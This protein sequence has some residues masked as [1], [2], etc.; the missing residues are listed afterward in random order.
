MSKIG[1]SDWK[2]CRMKRLTPPQWHVSTKKIGQRA[3]VTRKW[4]DCRTSTVTA[5]TNIMP[6]VTHCK[7]EKTLKL[8]KK[9]SP[10]KC[11]LIQKKFKWKCLLLTNLQRLK[12]QEYS[13]SPLTPQHHTLRQSS[14]QTAHIWPHL[15][16]V[17]FIRSD[18]VKLTMLRAYSNHILHFYHLNYLVEAWHTKIQKD[19]MPYF[20]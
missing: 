11:R 14:I 17:V 13:L 4:D 10:F 3:R 12:L 8:G 5:S 19:K 20:V 15:V 9:R 2:I 18:Q 16:L 7:G 6:R 1:G